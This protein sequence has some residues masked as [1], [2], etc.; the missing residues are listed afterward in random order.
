VL[1]LDRVM[2]G[3]LLAGGD[4]GRVASEGTGPIEELE[5]RGLLTDEGL[6]ELAGKLLEGLVRPWLGP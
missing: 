3:S 5:W 6:L 1:W 4:G 2:G